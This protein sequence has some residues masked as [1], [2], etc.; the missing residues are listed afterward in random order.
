MDKLSSMRIFS[1]V[2]RLGNFAAAARELSISRAMATKHVMHLEDQL[3][4]QLINRTTRSM[5]L[6][7]A[8]QAYLERC[9]HILDEIEETETA[10]S[11]LNS[12]PRGTLKLSSPPT[13]GK[14]YLGPLIADYVKPYPGV[15]FD[16]IVTDQPVD[17]IEWGLDLAFHLGRP[18]DSNMIIKRV[19]ST[20]MILCAA[21]EYLERHGT[22]QAP[23]QLAQHNCLSNPNL[24]PYQI[25]KFT[26]HGKERIIRPE[27]SL[28]SNSPDALRTA[29]IN[30]LGLVMMPAYTLQA[31]L[32]DGR[33]VAVLREF[34]SESIDMYAIYPHRRHL[35]A[36]VRTFL[37][38]VEQHSTMRAQARTLR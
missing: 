15:S 3:K 34:S 27:G 8:G 32:Q 28:Q 4:V 5:H 19:L 26:D 22:P 16:L 17:I 18:Q 29:A 37:D 25:W 13:F 24:P 9:T 14:L 11:Q 1:R 31:D 38:F 23:E 35:S 6:T 30:A 20:E 36:K 33:L 12:E 21:P 10:V 2:A 7:E